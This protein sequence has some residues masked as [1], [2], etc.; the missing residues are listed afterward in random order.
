MQQAIFPIKNHDDFQENDFIVSG[1]NQAAYNAVSQENALWGV[2]PYD[3]S[4]LIIGPKSCGKSFLAKIW[5]T[6]TGS[7]IVN[8]EQIS[9]ITIGSMGVCVEDIQ[10]IK[11]EEDLLHL[12]NMC[13]ERGT[14][15]LMTAEKLPEFALPDLSSRIKSINK[16]SIERSDDELV[17][18]LIFQFFSNNS[19]IV[20]R[21]VINY[22]INVLPRDFCSIREIILYINK[23]ALV[24]K[25]KLTISFVKECLVKIGDLNKENDENYV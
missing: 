7:V 11:Q 17:K 19:V 24:E 4:L 2:K 12:F 15:L 1:S 21:Q 13:F 6:R 25:R 23:V 18:I 16:I 3:N 5:Q 10:D 20:S 9:N 8:S 14:R 22:L